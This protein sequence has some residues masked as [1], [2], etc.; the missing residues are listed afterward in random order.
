MTILCYS[1][2]VKYCPRCG[3]PNVDQA[4][5]CARCGYNFNL[6]QP[7]AQPQQIPPPPMRQTI[8]PFP[9]Q[10]G[11]G[12][13]SNVAKY[14]F[15]GGGISLGVG[16]IFLG[17]AVLIPYICGLGKILPS[18]SNG[19][20]LAM[21]FIEVALISD[22]IAGGIPLFF[23]K[24]PKIGG[25]LVTIAFM[26]YII[27]FTLLMIPFS[28]A[29][30]KFTTPKDFDLFVESVLLLI[31]SIIGVIAYALKKKPLIAGIL[32]VIATVPIFIF[33]GT[34]FNS[35]LW[36]LA[37]VVGS[38]GYLFY[39]KNNKIAYIIASIASMIFGIGAII[40]GIFMLS[41]PSGTFCGVSITNYTV[42]FYILAGFICKLYVTATYG[43]V[44]LESSQT[45]IEIHM[46]TAAGIL[47]ILGG[48]LLVA[49]SALYAVDYSKR[50]S[51]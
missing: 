25:G 45:S 15:M 49:G 42:P 28:E 17:L 10:L 38:I 23:A 44:I 7:F 48:T 24:S 20:I 40:A 47:S 33:G 29:N 32:G 41:P 35:Y 51:Y 1:I 8:P 31:F 18:V 22:Y 4:A 11:S 34:L 12:Q 6:M 26:N 14:V 27:G 50:M 3:Y 16:I 5:F 39:G 46:L 19:T 36:S 43:L 9:N 2:M 30:F 13:L 21:L 37:L